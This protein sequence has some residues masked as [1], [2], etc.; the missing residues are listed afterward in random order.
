MPSY[1]APIDE[2]RFVLEKLLH[3]EQLTTLTGYSEVTPD[4][5]ASVLEEGGRLCEEVLAPL[6]QSGDAEGCHLESGNVATP[7]GFKGAYDAYV[8]GGWTAITSPEEF[9]GQALPQLARFVFDEMLCSANLSFSMYP[10]LSHG[11][12]SL[13]ERFASDEL[14]HRFLPRLVDGTWTGTMCLTES[15]AGT[16]LGIIRTKAVPAGDGAY[17]ISGTKIFISSGD[18]DLAENVIHLVL[19]K[20]PDAPPGTKGISLFL[21]PKLLPTDEG[22]PGMANG[23]SVGSI[24]HKMGIRGNATCV[25]NFENARGWL[26]GEAHRGMPV[27]FT[28]MN[29]ARLGVG[30]QGLGLAEVAYQ[31]ALSYT[32]DRL[33]GRSVRGAQNPKEDADPI[34]VHPDVRRMLMTMKSY[35]GGMRALSYWIGLMI[36]VEERTPDPLKRREASDLLALMTPVIKAFC[37]DVGFEI[38][39]LALQCYGGHGYIRE[40]GMEQFVRDARITQ[41]YEGTNGVQAMDLIGRKVPEG[42]G[43]LVMRWFEMARADL[44]AAATDARISDIASG[45]SNALGVLEKTTMSVMQRARTNAEELGAAASEYLRMFGLV[46]TG[47]MWVRMAAIAA[48]EAGEANAARVACARFYVQRLLPQT[49]ALEVQI[50]AGA[51][52]VMALDPQSL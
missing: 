4:L 28:M 17:L 51:M 26:I 18:H 41:I 22:A 36:D 25:L 44:A 16:D 1:K 23:V 15:Q 27:M 48:A 52:P 46:A 33:Q 35:I 21:V 39:N 34:V 12:T 2:M 38:T 3:V 37:T 7:K 9:G 20:L 13:L 30:L 47:W 14:K 42:E 49:G 19:A 5:L 29:S 50:N 10:G 43:R 11:V 45:V 31:N 6:N 24:E 8:A 32:K 40:F